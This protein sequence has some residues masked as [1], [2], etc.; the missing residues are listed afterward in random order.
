VQAL[1]DNKEKALLGRDIQ[2]FKRSMRFI[3]DDLLEKLHLA[4]LNVIKRNF[5]YGSLELENFLGITDTDRIGYITEKILKEADALI[6]TEEY[7]DES[8]NDTEDSDLDEEEAETET[9]DADAKA[10]SGKSNAIYVM[11]LSDHIQTGFE[12]MQKF[13]FSEERMVSGQEVPL[14]FID[15]ESKMYKTEIF[16]EILDREYSFVLTSNKIKIALDYQG[17]ERRD[18]RKLLSDSY[19]ALD[20]IRNGI[21]EF[22]NLI[23]ERDKVERSPQ[24]TPLQKSQTLH[25]LEADRSR[26]DNLIRN[27]FGN[28]LAGPESALKML[29]DDAKEEKHLL[30]NPDEVLHFMQSGGGR[31]RRLEGCTVIEAVA[32]AY[33]FIS[34]LRFRLREG[35][36]AFIGAKVDR[37]ISYNAK[38]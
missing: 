9:D 25:K 6:D 26:L 28:V 10:G 18:V 14:A 17:G 21:K 29:I 11:D 20:E 13:D 3:F 27:Q 12:I 30:Q 34:A 33:A 24:L 32:E 35:D 19:F 38:S 23:T 22:N 7:S 2:R 36:L 1:M 16:F 37:E 15:E 5:E 8:D 4:V 31:K